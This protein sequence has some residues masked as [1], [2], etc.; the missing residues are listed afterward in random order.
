MIAYQKKKFTMNR[1]DLHMPAEW[2]LHERTWME[3]PVKDSL[4]WAENYEEVCEGMLKRQSGLPNLN[5]EHDRNSDTAAEAERCEALP[6]SNTSQ[7][8]C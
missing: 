5:A 2:V 6:T 8:A 7:S 1:Y 4:V 3:W